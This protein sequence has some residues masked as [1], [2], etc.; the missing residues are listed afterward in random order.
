MEPPVLLS[1]IL[2]K[3]G[4]KVRYCFMNYWDGI[5]LGNGAIMINDAISFARKRFTLAH[6]IAHRAL[7]HHGVKFSNTDVYLQI[8]HEDHTEERAAN[9]FAAELLMPLVL[10]RREWHQYSV[11]EMSRRY[12]VS[13]EAMFYRLRDAGCLRG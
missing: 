11:E 7:D 10:I 6:E 12:L 2:S 5:Y 8:S 4:L 3:F 1:V 9:Q 13:Q